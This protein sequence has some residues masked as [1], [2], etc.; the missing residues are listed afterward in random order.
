MYG[1]W[2]AGGQIARDHQDELAHR[3]AQSHLFPTHGRRSLRE[4]VSMIVAFAP[5]RGAA[6]LRPG[7]GRPPR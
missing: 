2:H 3:A 1:N 6:S 7:S 4:R 5:R